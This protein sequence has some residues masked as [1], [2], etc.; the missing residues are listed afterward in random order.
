MKAY[1]ISSSRQYLNFPTK[2]KATGLLLSFR[3]KCDLNPK[4]W[5]WG[6]SVSDAVKRRSCWRTHRIPALTSGEWL[7]SPSW[8]KGLAEPQAPVHGHEGPSPQGD[9][10]VC[11]GAK[12]WPQRKGTPGPWSLLSTRQSTL[13]ATLWGSIMVTGTVDKGYPHHCSMPVRVAY[14]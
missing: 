5:K 10:R 13:T 6:F 11:E 12:N 1:K 9:G 2:L 7:P 8:R 14:R 4:T 3:E